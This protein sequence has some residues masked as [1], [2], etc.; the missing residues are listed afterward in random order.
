MYLYHLTVINFG[1]PF[2]VNDMPWYVG[3]M[4]PLQTFAGVLAQA[5]PWLS[6]PCSCA[7]L[8]HPC[9]LGLLFVSGAGSQR[10]MV[11]RRTIIRRVT[12][13]Y[14]ARNRGVCLHPSRQGVPHLSRGA[15]HHRQH[16]SS[17]VNFRTR[18][19]PHSAGPADFQLV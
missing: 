2:A 15:R 8:A 6:R 3:I 7:S 16:D 5:C 13:S 17:C 9:A 18:T 4:I 11:A 19:R 10:Q 14:C 1:N 12:L